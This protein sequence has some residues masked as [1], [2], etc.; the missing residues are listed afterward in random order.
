MSKAIEIKSPNDIKSKAGFLKVFL[1]GS[2][3]IIFTFW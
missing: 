3:E 1:A 2:I